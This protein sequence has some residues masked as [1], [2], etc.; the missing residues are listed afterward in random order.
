MLPDALPTPDMPT[1]WSTPWSQY[2]MT[3]R[4]NRRLRAKHVFFKLATHFNLTTFLGTV[5]SAR[6]LLRMRRE[7]LHARHNAE[8][9]DKISTQFRR[10]TTVLRAE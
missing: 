6:S 1:K 4:E 2:P 10:F 5:L 8:E 7:M 3:F 9:Y